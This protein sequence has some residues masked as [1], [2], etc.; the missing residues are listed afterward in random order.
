MKGLSI[1]FTISLFVFAAILGETL[2]RNGALPRQISEREN[3]VQASAIPLKF[4]SYRANN[5]HHL[6]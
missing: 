2:R 1:L 5:P 3:E 6:N 4:V